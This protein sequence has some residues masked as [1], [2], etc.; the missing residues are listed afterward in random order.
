MLPDLDNAGSVFLGRWEEEEEGYGGFPVGRG[1]GRDPP[2]YVLTVENDDHHSPLTPLYLPLQVDA[3]VCGRLRQRHQPRAAHIWLCA[4][5]QV[6]D[7]ALLGL[8][9]GKGERLPVGRF[10]FEGRLYASPGLTAWAECSVGEFTLPPLPCSSP[11]PPPPL[12]SGVSL[13][14]FEKE[15]AVQALIPTALP[16]PPLPSAVSPWTPSR[17]R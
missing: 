14:S 5:V 2:P 1:E 15:T 10:F 8:C 6:R 11:A 16:L 7:G 4:H 3:R 13:G 12:L 17:R 9:A